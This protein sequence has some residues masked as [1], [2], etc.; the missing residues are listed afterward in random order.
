[1]RS[2]TRRNHITDRNVEMTETVET[3]VVKTNVNKF[4]EITKRKHANN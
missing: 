1:M 4:S 3:F 2:I